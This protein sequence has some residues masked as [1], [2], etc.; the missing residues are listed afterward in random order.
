MHW[1]YELCMPVISCGNSTLNPT[2]PNCPVMLMLNSAQLYHVCSLW[3]LA[4]LFLT[5]QT[6]VVKPVSLY[7]ILE[8]HNTKLWDLLDSRMLVK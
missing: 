2:L 3:C 4:R 1:I 8:H 6:N 7:R 5:N